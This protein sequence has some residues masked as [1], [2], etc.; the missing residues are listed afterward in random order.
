MLVVEVVPTVATTAKGV[1]PARAVLGDRRA[2]G[3]RAS[4]R[5]ASSD[6]RSCAAPPG[7]CPGRSPPCPPTS[8]RAPTRT[9]AAAPGPRGPRRRTSRPGTASRAAA[10]ATRVEAEAVSWMTPNR[11]GGRPSICAQPVQDHELQLGGRGR[12]LPEHAV[13]VEGGGQHLGQDGGGGGGVGEVGEEAGMVPVR[14]AGDDEPLHVGQDA[15][16]RLGPAGGAAGMRGPHV[17]RPDPGQHGVAARP[18]RVAGDPVHQAAAFR[19]ER[20]EVDVA[21]AGHGGPGATRRR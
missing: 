19:A 2:P 18:P 1:K 6:R 5:N 20:L 13:D 17:A 16:Q 11:P 14:E 8:A 10:R 7:R 15:R 21:R 9:C 4:M 3:P 12:G